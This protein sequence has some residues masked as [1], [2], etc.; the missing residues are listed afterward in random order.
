VPPLH[1]VDGSLQD[2]DARVEYESV[3]ARYR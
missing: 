1:E 2:L 3:A